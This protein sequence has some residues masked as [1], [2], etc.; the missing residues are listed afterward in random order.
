MQKNKNIMWSRSRESDDIE[1]DSRCGYADTRDVHCKLPATKL[2][3]YMAH[4]SVMSLLGLLAQ[5]PS[6]ELRQ[7]QEQRAE[8][9]QA[10]NGAGGGALTGTG[11]VAM[12]AK[13][14]EQHCCYQK[15]KIRK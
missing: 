6:Q 5:V 11:D 12:E 2:P 13:G 14:A 10:Q 15:D 7:A 1:R 9:E 8:G 3:Y 4:T